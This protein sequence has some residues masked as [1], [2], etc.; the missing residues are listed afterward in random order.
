[1]QALARVTSK[2][3]R[4]LNHNQLGTTLAQKGLRNDTT[5][6]FYSVD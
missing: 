1:V 2:K 5:S 4:I 3:L 6:T